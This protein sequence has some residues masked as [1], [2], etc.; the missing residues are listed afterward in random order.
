MRQATK[1]RRAQ[2]RPRGAVC[3]STLGVSKNRA[4]ELVQKNPSNPPEVGGMLQDQ[5]E[6]SR[7][8][9]DKLIAKKTVAST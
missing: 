2:A 5:P 8:S 9:T 1:G 7:A 6:R 4:P 3:F